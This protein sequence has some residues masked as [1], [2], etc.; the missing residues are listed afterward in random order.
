MSNTPD[1]VGRSQTVSALGT[2]Y[3]LGRWDRRVWAEFLEWAKGRLPD[4]RKAAAEFLAMLPA[5]DLESRSAVV[6]AALAESTEHLSI[7]SPKVQALLQS[8]EGGTYLVY[9]LLKR[10]HPEVTEDLAYDVFTAVGPERM[11]EAMTRCAGVAPGGK[12]DSPGGGSAG[13]EAGR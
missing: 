9:L 5:D 1:H 12:A 4:P 11:Q 2:A 13:A 7:T 10:H 6:K 3:T 8:I